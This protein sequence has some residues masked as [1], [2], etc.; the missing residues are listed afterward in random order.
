VAPLRTS[1]DPS[2]LDFPWG[3]FFFDLG[4]SIYFFLFNIVLIGHGYTEKTLGLIT[5]TMAI[6]NLAG[7]IPAGKLARR[8]GLRPVLLVCFLLASIVF[9][10]RAILLSFTWQIPLTLLAGITLS[11]WAICVAPTVA[12]LTNERQRPFAFSLVFSLGI[13]VGAIGGFAGS[14]FPGWLS[15]RHV[16]IHSIRPDQLVLLGSSCIVALGIWPVTKLVF[17]D[18]RLPVQTRPLLSPGLLRFLAAIAVWSLVTGSFSPFAN[19]FFAQHLRM[20]LPE[21]GNAFSISQAVQV[22]AV[23]FAPV[24]MKRFGLVGG[25]VSTQL[26]VA[27]LLFA[28]AVVAH[29]AAATTAYVGFTAFQWMNEPG[30]YSLLMGMVPADERS[31][32][33]SYNNFVMSASQAIAATLAGGAFARYGYPFALRGIAVIALVAAALFWSMRNHPEIE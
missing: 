3:L 9:S 23:L 15:S 29:P 10:A 21:I 7:A 25:I 2:V 33:S 16:I 18:L 27:S 13:G 19:V 11:A 28:L 5:S 22:V 4:L 8:F 32:A 12:H 6:G 1:I 26:V 14:R 20:S 24:L 17:G 31:G 30:L